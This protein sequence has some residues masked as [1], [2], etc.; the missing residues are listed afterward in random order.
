M[1]RLRSSILLIFLPICL[2]CACSTGQKE[3]REVHSFNLSTDESKKQNNDITSQQPVMKASLSAIGDILV[4]DRVY[5]AAKNGDIYD[6]LPAFKQ[7]THVLREA[8]L[9]IANQESMIGG[10]E[11][12]LSGYPAFNS[13]YEIGDALQDAGI[14]LVTTANNH[15]LDRGVKAIEN[16]IAYWNQ[17]NMPYTGSFLSEE[18]KMKIR[19]LTK[20]DISFAF[21]A[22]TY[23][24]NGISPEE[25]YHVNYIDLDAM[26]S[27]IEFA[28]KTADLIVVSLHF[29]AEYEKLPNVTQEELVQHLSDLGVDIIIGHHSHVLQPVAW[30][31]GVRGNRTFVAYSLG[32]FF[33]GQQGDERNIGGIV[34]IEV[35]KTI[36]DGIT[37][38]ELIN[39][40]FYPT[41]TRLSTTGYYEVVPL[42]VGKPELFDS[43]R[44]HV[45]RWMPELKILK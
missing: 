18:D 29:G 26:R 15:A 3:K 41:F 27:E 5:N 13:P 19:T 7:V 36:K 39:P 24:T 45:S 16:S 32:N 30:V 12:G 14:D 2:L 25:S 20:N 28:E 42:Q 21:L 8:D 33:S 6:F 43:T 1:K 34:N 40:S 10:S 22:Y 23:G 9:T 11:V 4:H 17:I 38:I 31:N 44:K 37:T 35:K